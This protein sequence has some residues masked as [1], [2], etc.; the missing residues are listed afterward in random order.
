MLF[1][2][3]RRLTPH[4]QGFPQWFSRALTL[5]EQPHQD[6]PPRDLIDVL[7]DAFFEHT[8]NYMPLLHRPTFD[9]GLDEGL[10]LRDRPFG[11]VV[12]LVCANGARWAD[13]P[14]ITDCDGKG[15]GWRWFEK[16]EHARWLCFERPKLEDLQTCVVRASGLACMLARAG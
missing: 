16:V 15:R 12:L 5:D 14:R 7:A 8:N 2:D 9:K 4:P 3:L 11:S 6:F 1:C 13:D 10:H